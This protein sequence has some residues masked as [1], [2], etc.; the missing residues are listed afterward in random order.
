MIL[1]KKY[2]VTVQVI[3][4]FLLS[5]VNVLA[6]DAPMIC[7]VTEAVSCQKELDCESGSASNIDMPLFLKINPAKNEIISLKE[8]G[9]RKVS[10]I[11]QTNKDKDG[12]FVIYQGVEPGGAWSTV[13]N[14]ET[15]SMTIS[16]ASGESDAFIIYGAC[17]TSMLKP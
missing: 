16:I 11:R 9:E 6:A 2:F 17:S 5:S 4:A 14:K 8:N 10:V 12:K 3:A 7:A 1:N 15:G 13:V